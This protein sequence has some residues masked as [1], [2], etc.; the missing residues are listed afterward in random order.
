MSTFPA[1]AKLLFDGFSEQ[2]ESAIQ[3][4]E[5]ESGPPKQARVRSR[6]MVTRPVSILLDSKAD[7]EA[8]RDWFAG[9]LAEGALW[10]DFID[11]VSE[12]TK[13]A[14]FVG[15]GLDG[16]PGNSALS[17]WVIKHKIETWG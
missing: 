2:R 5:M 7:Y 3:R 1:Y 9:D 6:V 14:R 4:T 8:F 12:T 10:F 13:P 15:G 11:P 17:H 16:V